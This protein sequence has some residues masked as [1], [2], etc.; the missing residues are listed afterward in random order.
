MTKPSFNVSSDGRTVEVNGVV[1]NVFPAGPGN[2]YKLKNADYGQGFRQGTFGEEYLLFTGAY[3]NQ[4]DS[5][6]KEVINSMN[7]LF[8]IVGNTVAYGGTKDLMFAID[9]PGFRNR[10]IFLPD[11][12]TLI[13]K[14]G[15]KQIGNVVFGDSVRAMPRP[16]VRKNEY[17]VYRASRS[18]YP[19]FLTGLEDASE[20]IAQASRRTKKQVFFWYPEEMEISLPGFEEVGGRFVLS[21]DFREEG[22]GSGSIEGIP[23]K[24]D[25]WHSFGVRKSA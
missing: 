22:I 19:I 21:G 2:L 18:D 13:S 8:G 6:A 10:R 5:A 7:R 17:T 23:F 11:E 15:K 1:Y 24:F 9:E 20:L 3:L 25:G 14:L 12:K 16:A 4:Q